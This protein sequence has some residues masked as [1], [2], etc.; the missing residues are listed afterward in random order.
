[1][2]PSPSSPF[3]EKMGRRPVFRMPGCGAFPGLSWHLTDRDSLPNILPGSACK[4]DK[5][6][7]TNDKPVSSVAKIPF[8]SRLL[9]FIY[10]GRKRT[11]RNVLRWCFSSNV[12][13]FGELTP[14]ICYRGGGRMRMIFLSF[15]WFYRLHSSFRTPTCP[16][17]AS[18]NISAH[19]SK[20]ETWIL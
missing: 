15:T 19:L 8:W 1:M 18:R 6:M 9:V 11:F 3:P 7:F 17:S 2:L 14:N 10:I 20:C 12:Y 5:V 4:L 13:C 16:D